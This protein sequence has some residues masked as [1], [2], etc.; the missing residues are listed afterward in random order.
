[1]MIV[2]FGFKGVGKTFLGRLLA[3]RLRIPFYDLDEIIE[4]IFF[5]Q[6]GRVLK[7]PE[8]YSFLGEKE[9][10]LLETFALKS[11]DLNLSG[12]L[13]L[14][15]GTLMFEQNLYVLQNKAFLIFLDACFETIKS[16]VN[17]L[18]KFAENW[19]DFRNIFENRSKLYKTI[20]AITVNVDSSDFLRVLEEIIQTKLYGI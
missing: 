1:M 17:H 15:G 16:R 20:G 14:G 19:D 11:I 10:R 7:I 3:K 8:I 18:P 6:S 13:S 2:F 9:F 5:Q 12:I 4:E